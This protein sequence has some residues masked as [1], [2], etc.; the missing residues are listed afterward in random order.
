MPGKFSA[1]GGSASGGDFSKIEDRQKFENSFKDNREIKSENEKEKKVIMEIGHGGMPI[2]QEDR[3]GILKKDIKENEYYI[4]IDLLD[5]P[6]EAVKVN[7]PKLSPDV[8]KEVAQEDIKR[9]N[10]KGKIGFVVGS[11]ENL[12][13]SDKSV[14]R[15]IFKDVFGFNK[16]K[17][18][19]KNFLD[20]SLRVL[21]EGGE[22]EIIEE[23]SPDVASGIIM[24]ELENEN[25]GL[26]LDKFITIERGEHGKLKSEREINKEELLSE[27]KLDKEGFSDD[28]IYVSK[29]NFRFNKPFRI[30]FIKRNNK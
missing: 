22:I 9:E 14:D 7:F 23:Y 20:E 19:K 29:G 12:P 16:V 30:I 6:S 28:G 17:G 21:K 4:G 2:Y 3:Y 25:S 15:I 26:N 5:S 8:L 24:D 18:L 13:L 11:G 10:V 27:I 1:E